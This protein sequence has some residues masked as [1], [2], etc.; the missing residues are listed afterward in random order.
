[1][2]RTQQGF[3]L[4]E[5]IIVIVVLGILA[6]T[7]LPKFIDFSDDARL[8]SLKSSLGAMKSSS[9]LVYGKALLAKAD[10]KASASVEGI[11]IVY[12][13]P[14]ATS[15]GIGTA[16]EIPSDTI[17]DE[18]NPGVFAIVADGFTYQSDASN[19]CQVVYEEP[20]DVGE[21]PVLR[22]EDG[23]CPATQE[24]AP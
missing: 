9:K 12:G 24:D 22:L 23:A 6:V 11:D 13:Y 15:A 14:A 21:K 5:L 10:K 17:T 2:K 8:A 4:I 19:A 7:A 18:S 16:T 3:T 20:T 1:M